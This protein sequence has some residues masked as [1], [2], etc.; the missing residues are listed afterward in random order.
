MLHLLDEPLAAL[1]ELNRV[2]RDG[3]YLILPTY[4]NRD[5]KGKTSGFA[6]AVGKASAISI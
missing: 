3:G 2:C 1:A 5:W 6:S 4:M